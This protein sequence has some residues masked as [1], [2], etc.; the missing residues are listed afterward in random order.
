MKKL[1][2]FSLVLILSSLLIFTVGC[3]EESTLAGPENIFVAD[4]NQLD[5]KDKTAEKK[6]SASKLITVEDGGKLKLKVSYK[7]EYL[8]QKKKKKK[9][10]ISAEREFAPGTVLKDET[11]TLTWDPVEEMI[12]F[13]PQ[14]D[15]MKVAPLTMSVKGVDLEKMEIEKDNVKFV[16]FDAAGDEVE[17]VSKKIWFEKDSFGVDQASIGHYSRFGFKIEIDG[18]S[19]YGFTR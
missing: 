14:M 9:V 12:S 15:F 4:Q 17:M 16:Y 11:F 6:Y 19:R 3:Q 5:K 2:L 18:Y 1:I 13:H 7:G 10:K 8:G